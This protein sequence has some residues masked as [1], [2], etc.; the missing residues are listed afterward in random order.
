VPS[1]E[2]VD[3]ALGVMER[4]LRRFMNMLREERPDRT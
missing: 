1:D 3:R 4:F 2:D